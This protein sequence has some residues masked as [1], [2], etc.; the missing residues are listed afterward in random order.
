MSGREVKTHPGKLSSAKE[1]SQTSA[2]SHTSSLFC[3]D[4]SVSL[5]AG[6]V[7]EDVKIPRALEVSSEFIPDAVKDVNGSD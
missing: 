4:T 1:F 2:S 6:K 3:I 7:E 5:T